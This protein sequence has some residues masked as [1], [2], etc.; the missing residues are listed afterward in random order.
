MVVRGL[1]GG[2]CEES[3]SGIFQG[4]FGEKNLF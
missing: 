3:G 4:N 2:G 1:F